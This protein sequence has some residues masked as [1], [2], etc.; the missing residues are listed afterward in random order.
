MAKVLTGN[1]PF[2]DLYPLTTEPAIIKAFPQ[3]RDDDFPMIPTLAQQL[4]RSDL[5]DVWNSEEMKECWTWDH[6][7]RITA[8]A[9]FKSLR[10]RRA[11][12]P[13]KPAPISRHKRQN[14]RTPIHAILKRVSQFLC[15]IWMFVTFERCQLKTGA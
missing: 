10:P 4:L 12:Q 5:K 7:K 15:I 9:L 2:A 13:A 14:N 11:K 8:D 6:I 1:T 3:N